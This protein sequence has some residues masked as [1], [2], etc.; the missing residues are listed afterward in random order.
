MIESALAGLRVVEWSQMVAGPYCAKLLAD[1]GAEVIKVEAPCKGDGARSHGPF[2]GDIPDRERSGLF[3]LLNTNKL[4]ITLDIGSPEGNKI[5]RKLVEEANVLIT[6]LPGNRL[7]ELGLDYPAV[8]SHN[9]GLVFVSI[10]PFGRTGPYSKYRAYPLNTFNAGGEAYMT[11]ADTPFMDRPPLKLANYAGE[12]M[13]GISSA[14]AVLFAYFHSLRTG[15]GQ[16]VDV[17]K[18]EALMFL[19]MDEIQ[20]Y[21]HYGASTSRLTRGLPIGGMLPCKDGYVAFFPMRREHWAAFFQVLQGPDSL[22]D[23]NL[24]NLNYLEEHRKELMG[25]AL[26]FLMKRTRQEIFSSPWA[27]E[28][29]LGPVYSVDEVVNSP[30]MQFRGYFVQLDHSVAGKMNYPSAPYRFSR[31]PWAVQ[32]AAPRLGEHNADIYCGRLGYSREELGELVA[33]GII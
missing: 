29:P 16:L 5:F 11:P 17:S 32:R 19:N 6:D 28:C 25:M 33:L 22:K 12:F 31:T 21:P 8:Q 23:E 13:C 18:Q 24:T 4:G 1:L 10:T 20:R 3:L 30:Q 27:K 14:S 15:E 9:P 7:Q 26:E 2:P